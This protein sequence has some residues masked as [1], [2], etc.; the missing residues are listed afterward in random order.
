MEN[1]EFQVREQ[2]SLHKYRTE[3]PNI[4]EELGLDP[5][6][7]RLYAH[8]KKV[9]GDGGSCYESKSTLEE[10]LK[11]SPTTIKDRNRV[12]SQPFDMLDGKPLIIVKKRRGSK[13]QD[14]PV[15]IEIV[16]I[17]NENMTLLS[18]KFAG[19]S[20]NKENNIGVVRNRGG[21]R[22][23]PTKK[24]LLKKNLKRITKRRLRRWLFPPLKWKL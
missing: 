4:I 18:N 1:Q 12:L 13:N 8:Y 20:Q 2:N 6:A 24:N 9:A 14:L 21:G 16:D 5:Y 10:N 19:K 15:L 23:T 11:M 17:W 3:L 22:Q 7:F